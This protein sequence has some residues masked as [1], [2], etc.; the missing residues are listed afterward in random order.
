MMKLNKVLK[1]YTFEPDTVS[2]VR[3]DDVAK[4]RF[5]KGQIVA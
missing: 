3:G 4:V 5:G 2:L 1:A